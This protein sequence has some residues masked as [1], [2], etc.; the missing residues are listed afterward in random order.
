VNPLGQVPSIRDGEFTLGESHSIL[1]YLCDTREVADNWYP[2]D[3]RKRATINQYLDWRHSNMRYS[4]HGYMFSLLIA[5]RLKIKVTENEF[6]RHESRLRQSLRTME[7]MHS[8]NKYLCGDAMSIADISGVCQMIQL[9]AA[10]YDLSN[11]GRIVE[12]INEMMSYQEMKE[13]HE[14][15]LEKV[16]P[17]IKEMTKNELINLSSK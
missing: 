14:F 8:K 16:L 12:W 7:T 2:N 1:R 3:P 6:S 10:D 9:R 17:R 13:V 15:Y 5:D 4:V 11:Y